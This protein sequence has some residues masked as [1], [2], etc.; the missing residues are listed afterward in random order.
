MANIDLLLRFEFHLMSSWKLTLTVQPDD[1]CLRLVCHYKDW[2]RGRAELYLTLQSGWCQGHQLWSIEEKR[3]DPPPTG[4]VQ[5][6]PGWKKQWKFFC[7][8]PNSSNNSIYRSTTG[9]DPSSL[10]YL[11]FRFSMYSSMMSSTITNWLNN[12]TLS[13]W[14]ESNERFQ[15]MR[16]GI[17]NKSNLFFFLC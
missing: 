16:V 12:R 11:W 2:S 4:I 14:N 15:T 8:F 5:S 13:F 17:G 9:V 3:T 7:E 1:I 6:T 10:R